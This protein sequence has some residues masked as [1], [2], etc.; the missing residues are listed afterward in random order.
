MAA[1]LGPGGKRVLSVLASDRVHLTAEDIQE[2]LPEVGTATV[3]RNLDSLEQQ[4]LIKKFRV[5][6]KSAYYEYA[7]DEH[8]HFACDQ[9]GQI[10]DMP[11][12]PGG[13]LSEVS[14]LCGHE[15]HACDVICRGICKNCKT[16]T[17]VQNQQ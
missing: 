12:N 6:A 14:R 13:L 7:R 3:Y 4:G 1:R 15:M 9:C 2:K 16:K 11:C 5:D 17:Q 10:F 8:L